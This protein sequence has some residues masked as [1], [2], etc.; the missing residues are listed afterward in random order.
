MSENVQKL[1]ADAEVLQETIHRGHRLTAVAI[2][3]VAVLA[4]LGTFFTHHRSISALTVKN[5]AILSQA[6]ASDAYGKYEAKQVRYQVVQ[7]L[8]ASGIPRTPAGREQMQALADRER[9]SSAAV[10]TKAQT[11]EASSEADDVRSEKIL[12]SYE[13]LQFATSFF[14]IAIVLISIS[15]L[16]R[17]RAF[18]GF[19]CAL[20]LVGIAFLIFGFF[21]ASH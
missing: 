10:L 17:T 19:G 2:A 3:I 21:Q 4:A 5:Q 11:L 6:R 9:D 13:T 18:L 8:I 15:T 20:S 16:V 12:K 1:L 14:E 7:V